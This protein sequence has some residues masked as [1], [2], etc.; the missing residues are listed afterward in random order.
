MNCC[1]TAISP[2][3]GSNRLSRNPCVNV[4]HH[5]RSNAVSKIFYSFSLLKLFG[6]SKSNRYVLAF[7]N[8]PEY[9]PCFTFLLHAAYSGK[10][11][12]AFI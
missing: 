1:N 4:F 7:V 6:S 2:A 3:G 8:N 5:H 11:H 12:L 10:L 9:Q